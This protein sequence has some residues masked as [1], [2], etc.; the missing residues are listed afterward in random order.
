[1]KSD[2][3]GGLYGAFAASIWGG[4]YVVSKVILA[5]IPPWPLIWLRYLIGSLALIALALAKGVTWRIRP[6]DWFVVLAIALVGY[7]LS[8]GAQFVGTN[9]ANAAWGSVLTASTPAFMVLFA[10]P[11]LGER[12]SW[13]KTLGLLVS[14][15]GVWGIVGGASASGQFLLGGVILTGAAVSWAL[16]SVLVKRLAPDTSTLVAT[17]YAIAIAEVVITPWALPAMNAGVWHALHQ[18]GILAGVLY[19]GAISTALA[20]YFWNRGLQLTTA[21]VSGM[22]FFAQPVVG[23]VLGAT[24]LGERLT[25]GFGVGSAAI[26]LGGF[27]VWH[28]HR[29]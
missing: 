4:M 1:M 26:M 10:R 25:V 7:V 12:L 16:S 28:S 22:V 18:V 17:V 13:Q 27:L 19:L 14:T 8:I 29:P 20:F 15:A 24:L 2:W 3:R 21:A 11:L 6:K 5:D 23:A 9:W